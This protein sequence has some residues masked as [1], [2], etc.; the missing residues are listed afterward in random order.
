MSSP[1]TAE[2][3]RNLLEYRPD[4]GRFYW[5]VRRGSALP[6][7]EAGSWQTYGYRKIV[8]ERRPYLAHRLAWLYVYGEHPI[9]VIDHSNRDRTDNRIENLEDRPRGRNAANR[10]R[11]SQSGFTGICFERSK[12]VARFGVNGRTFYLGSYDTPKKAASRYQTA[13][14][15][16]HGDFQNAKGRRNSSRSSGVD[17]C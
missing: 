9:G 1:L 5:K 10:E 4:T 15:L 12:W 14:R 8:I 2:Q 3:L 17:D 13:A 11:R 16:L 6:G 7:S